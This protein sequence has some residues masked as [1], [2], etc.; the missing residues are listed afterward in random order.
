M[1]QMNFGLPQPNIVEIN[2]MLHA[3]MLDE[4]KEFN[5]YASYKKPHNFATSA[6]LALESVGFTDT[7]TDSWQYTIQ[8]AIVSSSVL[9]YAPN[10][11]AYTFTVEVYDETLTL[12]PGTS[13][14]VPNGPFI[15]VQYTF[16]QTVPAGTKLR[17]KVSSANLPRQTVDYNINATIVVE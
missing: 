10:L 11:P 3:G 5:I 17:Y 8:S 1:N 16:D 15:K 4:P 13:A 7:A 9:L 2:R 6:W 14:E 12:I